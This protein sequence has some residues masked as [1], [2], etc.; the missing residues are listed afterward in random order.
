MN[1]DNMIGI[2]DPSVAVYHYAP[3]ERIIQILTTKKIV[4]TNPSKWDDPFENYLLKQDVLM[5]DLSRVSLREL[6]DS[7]FGQCWTTAVENDA[8][9]RIYSHDK[10]SVR[11]KSRI[12][13]IANALWVKDD[14]RSEF[15]FFV[16]RVEYKKKATYYPI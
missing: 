3:I 8:L 12:E 6:R 10:R 4:L 11:I 1:P 9:W 7:W 16:G 14:P 5:K 15:K 2:N 13:A